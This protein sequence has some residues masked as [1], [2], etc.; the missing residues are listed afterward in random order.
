MNLI[1]PQFLR[2]VLK[3]INK[4]L[5]AQEQQPDKKEGFNL[6]NALSETAH[7]NQQSVILRQQINAELLLNRPEQAFLMKEM[8]KIPQDIQQLLTLLDSKGQ[9]ITPEIIKLLLESNSREVISKLIKLIQQDPYNSQNHEQL[10]QLMSLIS[11]IVPS[12]DASAQEILTHLTLLYLPWL[13]LSEQQKI[14]IEFEKKQSGNPE[15]DD[16]V[17]M[18]VFISTI[19]LGRFKV[20]LLIEKNQ[21]LSI[22]IQNTELEEKD[23]LKEIYKEIKKG[24]KEEHI[25]AET[26]MSVVKQKNFTKSEKQ[27]VTISQMKSISPPLIIASQ[28]IARIILEYD[29]RAS[30]SSK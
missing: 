9:P 11:Q 22:F 12:K 19:N 20:T 27:D 2:L 18:V 14:R 1:N 8:L 30:I 4:T 21:M 5:S 6:P 17:V 23:V 7:K 10:K 28:R 26:H 13:P 3:T 16:S 29:E 15:E 25:N 24:L